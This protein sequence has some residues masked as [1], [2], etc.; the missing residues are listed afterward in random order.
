MIGIE[1]SHGLKYCNECGVLDICPHGYSIW[2]VIKI[3]KGRKNVEFVG[4][5]QS[6]NMDDARRCARNVG[7]VVSVCMIRSSH[8]AKTVV[9]VEYA[10][11][12]EGR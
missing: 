7:V 8:S 6:V 10:Y 2:F 5:T 3:V 4:A 9:V 11:T 1:C 12:G